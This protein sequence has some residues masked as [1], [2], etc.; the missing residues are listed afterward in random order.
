MNPN[1][2]LFGFRAA[3]IFGAVLALSPAA[4]DEIFAVKGIKVDAT[5]ASA[6]E[7]RDAAVAQG[8]P[9]AWTTLFRRL[10]RERDWPSQPQLDDLTLMRMIRG[11]EIANERRSSTRY[12]ADIT[13][14]FNPADVKRVLQQAGVAYTETAGKRVLVIPVVSGTAKPYELSSAWTKA[15]ASADLGGG[16]V[17]MVLPSGAGGDMDVLARADLPRLKWES[18]SA[19]ATRYNAN[20]VL[21]AEASS[22]GEQVI[23]TLTRV[24]PGSAAAALPLPS[25]PGYAA[26]AQAT[27]SAIREVWKGRN[28]INYGQHS[29][30]TA[31]VS[32]STGQ[33]WASMRTRLSIVPSVA[34]VSVVALSLNSAEIEISYVGA[35]PQLHEAL[36]GQGLHL[37]QGQG[38]YL[39]GGAAAP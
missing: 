26:A 2:V 33:E 1:R 38:M 20:E 9:K 12:L 10:A 32:F 37:S 27:A 25:Q 22:A 6:T 7:A 13:Y 15:W 29:K 8:R 18:L 28:A 16:V 3:L 23:V 34:E 24:T 14:E 30:L 35:L 31:L 5:A 39:L 21:I 11:I 19:I 36:E 4:A 17:P